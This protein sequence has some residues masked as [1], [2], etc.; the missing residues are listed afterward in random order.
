MNRVILAL[1]ASIFI[2]LINQIANAEEDV[3]ESGDHC[4]AYR[5]S[6]TLFFVIDIEV[7][8]KSCQINSKI[9]WTAEKDKMLFDIRVPISSLDSGIG[10]RDKSIFRIL[11]INQYPDIRFITALIPLTA[12]HQAFEIGG[13]P[14]SGNLEVAGKS[15]PVTFLLRIVKRSE[16][17]IIKGKLVTTFSNLE[18]VL[19]LV[20]PWG[21]LEDPIDYLEILVHLQLDRIFESSRLLLI[22]NKN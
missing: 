3:F 16:K 21:V 9:H 22:L 7:I 11:K 15:F 12:L 8:G 17:I 18:V 13:M 10:R 6:R 14:I 2:L 4:L 20:G 1:M 19:P 5:A